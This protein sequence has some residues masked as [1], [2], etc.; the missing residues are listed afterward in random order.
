M[1]D[2]ISPR[3]EI[4]VN[5][6]LQETGYFAVQWGD[7]CLFVYTREGGCDEVYSINC[8]CEACGNFAGLLEHMDHYYRHKDYE[9]VVTVH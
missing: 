7:G 6:F 3:T 5:Q 1:V 8:G 2:S 9:R 4:I